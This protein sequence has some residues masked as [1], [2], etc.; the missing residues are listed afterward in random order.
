[1]SKKSGLAA[2]VVEKAE[3]VAAKPAELEGLAAQWSRATRASGGSC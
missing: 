3:P 2:A 1:M